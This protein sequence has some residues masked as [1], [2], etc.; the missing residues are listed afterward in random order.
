A[1]VGNRRPGQRGYKKIFRRKTLD[2]ATVFE[3]TFPDMTRK[4]PQPPTPSAQNQP[5]GPYY[6]MPMQPY[7][8]PYQPNQQHQ[9]NWVNDADYNGFGTIPYTGQPYGQTMLQN[10]QPMPSSGPRFYESANAMP[11]PNGPPP[12]EFVYPEYPRDYQMQNMRGSEN[13]LQADSL[14]M[15]DIVPPN[16]HN[17]P[18][19]TAQH[20]PPENA[21]APAQHPP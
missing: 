2:P 21:H 6:N 19:Q 3:P 12:N 4:P 17:I 16:D 10:T 14:Q 1:D 20:L 5:Y 13:S 7:Q 8:Q 9:Q 11:G 15:S 18:E